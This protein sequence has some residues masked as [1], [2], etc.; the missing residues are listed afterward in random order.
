MNFTSQMPL[1]KVVIQ[2]FTGNNLKLKRELQGSHVIIY[3]RGQERVKLTEKPYSLG[4][5]VYPPG[6]DS[7]CIGRNLL[8]NYFWNGKYTGM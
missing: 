5:V 6:S 1:E 4:S 2:T 3:M 7:L 8:L